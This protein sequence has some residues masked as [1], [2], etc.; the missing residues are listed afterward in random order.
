MARAIATCRTNDVSQEMDIRCRIVASL[1][2]SDNRIRTS[3][4]DTGAVR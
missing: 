2:R 4:V 1:Q 3:H